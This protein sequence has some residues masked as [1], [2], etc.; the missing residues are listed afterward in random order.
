M[1]LR[2]HFRPPPGDLHDWAGLYGAWPA[3]MAAA[4][5]ETL[6]RRYV[7]SPL[8][9]LGASPSYRMRV[10]DS[11]SGRRVVASVE[12]VSPPNKGHSQERSA[13]VAGCASLLRD[14]VSVVMLDVVTTFDFNLSRE[15]LD[16]CGCAAP[17]SLPN[18]PL[19]AVAFRTT[20]RA[21]RDWIEVWSHALSLGQP[22][23]T[24]PLWLA[25]GLAV[26]LELEASYEATCRILRIP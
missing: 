15:L 7:A 4:L 3:M 17:T 22:L 20:T 25:G 9:R 10:F 1:P 24:L 23:P 8:V 11:E 14:R 12:L 19:Y 2:D 5:S 6:P 26:P 13:F 18:T 16:Q 21:N